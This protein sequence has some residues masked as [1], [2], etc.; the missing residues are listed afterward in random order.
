MSDVKKGDIV[1]LKDGVEVV[2]AFASSARRG[3][4]IFA[5][6]IHPDTRYRVASRVSQWGNVQLSTL[7]GAYVGILAADQLEVVQAARRLDDFIALAAQARPAFE[8][9]GKLPFKEEPTPEPEPGTVRPDGKPWTWHDVIEGDQVTAETVGQR[10]GG[11]QYANRVSGPA[12]IS[13]DYRTRDHLVWNGLDLTVHR[14][15]DSWKIVSL[16]RAKPRTLTERR[17]PQSIE[18]TRKI[19]GDKIWNATEAETVQKGYVEQDDDDRYWLY[20]TTSDGK[21]RKICLKVARDSLRAW[22]EAEKRWVPWTFDQAVTKT[23]HAK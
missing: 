1:V 21:D 14:R 22:L 2:Q 12:V 6:R 10:V 4:S 15:Y 19:S 9:A 7:K 17:N 11:V 13:Q 16:F 20:F 3:R 8:S 23:H 5:G 18:V